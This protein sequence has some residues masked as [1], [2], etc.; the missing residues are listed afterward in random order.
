MD[1]DVQS[2]YSSAHGL[3]VPPPTHPKS[4]YTDQSSYGGLPTTQDAGIGSSTFSGPNGAAKS[5][6]V[7]PKTAAETHQKVIED[8]FATWV[9]H[10]ATIDE[11]PSNDS[12]ETASR[13]LE[14]L[15]A[16]DLEV[17]ETPEQKRNKELVLIKLRDILDQWMQ[18]VK[19]KHGI[20]PDSPTGNSKLLPYGSYK[21]GVS[22]PTGDIDTLVLSPYFVDRDED[23]FGLLH[24]LLSE[25]AGSNDNIKELTMVNQQHTIMPLIKMT[26]YGIPIDM[27]FARVQYTDDL[28]E[29]IRTKLYN[30]EYLQ[31]MDEKMKRSFNGYR[32]A[33]MILKSLSRKPEESHLN[34]EV[35][36]WLNMKREEVFRTTLKCI[37]LWAKNNGLDS[38]KMGY[39]GGIAWA[40]LT[41]KICKLF[42]Y[43][44]PARLLE[45]FFWLYGTEWLWD[46]WFVRIEKEYPDEHLSHGRTMYI[47]TPSRPQM[48]STHN[49]TLSTLEIMTSRMKESHNLVK[50]LLQKF[51]H[52][53]VLSPDDPGAKAEWMS[54]FTKYNFF[55][56][57]EHFIEINILGGKEADYLRWQGF[58]EAKIRLLCERFEDLLKFYDLKIHPW[59]N[60]YDRGQSTFKKFP[61]ATTVYIG[62]QLNQTSD[63]TIDL[64]I[65]VIRFI[66]FL[67][68]EWSRDNP[69]K[70]D[71]MVYNVSIFYKTRAEIPQEVLRAE[72]ELPDPSPLEEGLSKSK[73]SE[74]HDLKENHLSAHK[75]A[76]KDD[77]N[78]DVEPIDEVE[79]KPA[80]SINSLN[81]VDVK[82]PRLATTHSLPPAPAEP[83]EMDEEPINLYA[84][85]DQA[86]KTK[87]IHEDG[88]SKRSPKNSSIQ[89]G[90]SVPQ[91]S[92]KISPVVTEQISTPK[93]FKFLGTS[94]NQ[95]TEPPH[96]N[97]Q[98]KNI[99]PGVP[100]GGTTENDDP[101]SSSM[102]N[103][104]QK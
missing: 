91:K 32:N 35:E 78:Q 14:Q 53:E 20:P 89:F 30:E 57:Y 76:M 96:R 31:P 44:C 104:L 72:L 58:V 60:T 97:S 13:I 46:E 7:V 56:S 65:P 51:S 102:L 8:G 94:E 45:K 12:E 42:P 41:A 27:V 5:V 69:G 34:P 71:P 59:P 3:V 9:S 52:V 98:W 21:L 37:K 22:S 73:I 70:R 43:K 90:E 80:Q 25:L 24:G 47:I 67:E 86:M 75:S 82:S 64:N 100:D 18:R 77:F 33:E 10:N 48:N 49:V 87:S 40:M 83:K 55:D 63:D 62:L 39:V 81:G 93:E 68:I 2:Y 11:D 23:F 28:D 61:Y 88:L 92:N 15:L 29:F 101:N 4:S 74:G 1:G 79:L 19:K 84:Q 85:F 103:E 99:K 26:F 6:R 16:N 66:E 95:F 54:L 50:N 38:N 36:I 17:Y